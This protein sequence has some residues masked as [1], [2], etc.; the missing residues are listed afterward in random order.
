VI[1]HQ[2][3]PVLSETHDG[4]P[5]TGPAVDPALALASHPV[6]AWHHL[7]PLNAF[8]RRRHAIET[9]IGGRTAKVTTTWPPLGERALNGHVVSVRIDDVDGELRIPR[10]LLDALLV[11]ADATLSLD[12]L[13][14]DVAATVVEF[15]LSDALTAIETSLACRLSLLSIRPEW[16]V[17]AKGG[18]LPLA[19]MVAWDGVETSTCELL[20]AP[21]DALRLAHRLDH[22][23]GIE[24]SAVDFPVAMCLRMAAA[25]VTVGEA[26][27][28]VP[29]DVVLTDA[30]CPPDGMAIAVIAEHLVTPVALTPTDI[31]LTARPVR[32]R[33][34]PW[35]WSMDKPT[36]DLGAAVLEDS[37][38]DDLPVRLVFEVGR[39][40]L[41]LG[42]IQRLAPGSVVPLARPVDEPLDIVANGKRLGRG[43]LVRIGNS[44][45]V[46]IVSLVG[47]D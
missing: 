4:S 19:F 45:G 31:V 35:E 30:E 6:V 25:T 36:E 3:V 7:R 29:D 33:G 14:A 40:E 39:V 9:T 10:R 13:T 11:A 27:R 8:Y 42:E 32:G 24:K 15:T 34:S 17:T 44:L 23:I 41:S 21:R 26:K 16:L 38:L 18:R 46:R 37:D 28:L 43:T 20:L 1:S 22:S 12:H 2:A 47:N 5:L